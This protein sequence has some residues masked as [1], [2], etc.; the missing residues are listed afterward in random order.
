MTS[1]RL[2]LAAAAAGVPGRIAHPR[3]NDV[4]NDL[5]T[6][7]ESRGIHDLYTFDGHIGHVVRVS[8]AGC[9]ISS[10]VLGFLLPNGSDILGPS[11]R[12]G[13]DIRLTQDGPYQLVVNAA[14]GGPG[15]Y[16]FVFQI[17]STN[18]GK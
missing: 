4:R 14:D 17:A 8:G 1:M 7:V 18:S 6:R 13:S 16:H 12:A 15:E 11:C 9:D 10:L 3:E 5:Y 2:K